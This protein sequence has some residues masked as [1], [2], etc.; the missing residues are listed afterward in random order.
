MGP[1]HITFRGASFRV[2]VGRQYIV[3]QRHQ[4]A[5]FSL[6]AEETDSRDV[7]NLGLRIVTVWKQSRLKQ[8][9]HPLDPVRYYNN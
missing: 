8:P 1:C 7:R 5:K 4:S 3:A 6:E 2:V 9:D